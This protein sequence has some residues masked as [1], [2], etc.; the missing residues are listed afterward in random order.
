MRKRLSAG[1]VTLALCLS[2]ASVSGGEADATLR[3]VS[4][5]YSVPDVTVQVRDIPLPAKLKA[6]LQERLPALR[7]WRN[8]DYPAPALSGY[9]FSA[10][11]FPYAVRADFNGDGV[12]DAV[13]SGH[14]GKADVVLALV[15]DGTSYQLVDVRSRLGGTDAGPRE[16]L[17]FQK[18]GCVYSVGDSAPHELVQAQ[19]GF[20]LRE[21]KAGE[22]DLSGP[23][24]EGAAAYFWGAGAD[25]FRGE[26][27]DSSENAA[28]LA[29][30][31][32]FDPKTALFEEK[33]V[34]GGK[35]A[36]VKGAALKIAVRAESGEW[37]DAA[38]ELGAGGSFRFRLPAGAKARSMYSCRPPA[39][40]VDY[41][42]VKAVSSVGGLADDIPTPV[43]SRVLSVGTAFGF[44][45]TVP[46]MPAETRAVF[47]YACDGAG[48]SAGIEP[49]GKQVR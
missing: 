32:R 47:L 8:A 44:Y 18:K 9:P 2:F 23:G 37:V 1:L 46:A 24:Q 30:A 49:K 17:V 6:I 34:P 40:G 3:T 10:G 4:S 33:A 12:E 26:L 41:W 36:W 31:A 7:L 29:C 43:S 25:G 20:A 28:V 14:D 5:A 22:T 35:R 27:L 13:L 21:V 19:D 48:I 11:S 16:T 45:W 15:S 39:G 42:K 38:P